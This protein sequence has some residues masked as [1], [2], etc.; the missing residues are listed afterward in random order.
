MADRRLRQRRQGRPTGV[1]GTRGMVAQLATEHGQCRRQL[2]DGDQLGRRQAVPHLDAVTAEQ[3][4][5]DATQLGAARPHGVG[6]AVRQGRITGSGFG[7]V[8]DG[9]SRPIGRAA[10]RD[11]C[12]RSRTWGVPH[13]RGS[14]QGREPGV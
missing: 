7:H 1:V 5:A 6:V 4:R 11:N 3:Q 10:E 12:V 2:G 9:G 14:N 13:S 8:G